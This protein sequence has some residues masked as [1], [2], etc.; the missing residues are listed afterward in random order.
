M[1]QLATTIEPVAPLKSRPELF[2]LGF[3]PDMDMERA[4]KIFTE[5]YGKAPATL[6]RFGGWLR[7]G[8]IEEGQE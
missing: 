4:A 8:P 2:W 3:T 5:R 7:V 6:T 1:T